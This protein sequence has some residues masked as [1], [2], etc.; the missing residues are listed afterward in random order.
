MSIFGDYKN[1]F[2]D[3]S[4]YEIHLQRTTEKKQLQNL[5]AFLFYNRHLPIKP[6]DLKIKRV[7][8]LGCGTGANTHFLSKLF[9]GHSII[10]LDRSLAHLN[11]ARK[12]NVPR[13]FYLPIPFEDYRGK[14]FS[15]ILA[16]HV[17]QYID[18]NAK[19]FI[20]KIYQSLCPGGLAMIVQQTN[21]GIAQM[22]EHQIPFL[23]NPRFRNWLIHK[24]Y[25][26][27]VQE[28]GLPHQTI[29]LTCHID[30]LDFLNPSDDDRKWLEFVF[31]LDNFGT[32]P[33][34]FKYHLSKLG[35]VSPLIHENGIIIL[36]K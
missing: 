22:I 15:F 1:E 33:N 11:Q 19:Q 16:S 23:D 4:K 35:K 25:V 21:I 20:K 24:D 5:I 34:E 32:M 17:L 12:K 9:F 2:N 26:S 14:P 3:A 28:L 10:A 29:N 27:I 6:K 7:L 18:T 13:V 36:F 31:C 30:G 8:D